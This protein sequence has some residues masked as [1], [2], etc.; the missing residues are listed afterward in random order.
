M[1]KETF[2][3]AG[4]LAFGTVVYSL[5]QFLI[6]VA[7]ARNGN[8]DMLG[9][10]AL[11]LAVSA[12]VFMFMNMRL[13]F[14]IATDVMKQ[15][16]FPRYFAFRLASSLAGFCVIWLVTAIIIESQDIVRVF[17]LMAAIKAVEAL[18]DAIYGLYQRDQRLHFMALSM[19]LSGVG[20]F[21][22]AVL[23]L[24]Q[25][26]FLDVVL[27]GLLLARV[28]VFVFVD[29]VL[30]FRVWGGER[31]PGEA[32]AQFRTSA[33]SI[34]SRCWP[35][36]VV[37]LLISLNVNIP[38]YFIEA[39]MGSAALGIF[40]AIVYI[41]I[42]GYLVI[43]TMG[44]TLMPQIAL[45]FEVG[46]KRSVTRLMFV[47]C[48]FGALAGLISVFFGLIVGEQFLTIVYGE[49]YSVH[50]D[51]FVLLLVSGAISYVVV[52][53]VYVLTA[54]GYFRSQLFI[55]VSDLL[56]IS[57]LCLLLVPRY[58][59]SGGAVA[60]M[61]SQAVQLVIATYL[62]AMLL[63]R[64]RRKTDLAADIPADEFRP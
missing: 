59:L 58:G 62:I 7:L 39:V 48:G 5:T 57:L 19:V 31:N 26:P 33:G 44:Q 23:A 11:A 32:I 3:S 64:M 27:M 36:G 60:M 12:P 4:F 13:R 43:G 28:L 37:A 55:Y 38:R 8:A 15:V 49:A 46:D 35:L 52:G 6:L 29:L 30:W 21:V 1:I 18:S 25:S 17:V 56:A 45:A 41:P 63:L 40:T 10:Y 14:V 47:L 20:M 22:A 61:A 51:L 42:A 24:Q 50:G 9:E 16:A 2:R 34:L 54:S 53:M